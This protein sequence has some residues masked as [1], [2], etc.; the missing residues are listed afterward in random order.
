MTDQIKR[1]YEEMADKTLSFGCITQEKWEYFNRVV[2]VDDTAIRL[3]RIWKDY[4]HS[5]LR[6][7]IILDGNR[8]KIIGHPV[9]IGD[10][11]HWITKNLEYSYWEW[12]IMENILIVWNKYDKPIE[13]QPQKTI[14]FVE[15]LIP[16]MLEK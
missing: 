13:D 9:M 12:S 8:N 15:S 2:Y 6:S 14:D 5:Y 4:A 1:I 11:L 3:I 16:N 7:E 10:V